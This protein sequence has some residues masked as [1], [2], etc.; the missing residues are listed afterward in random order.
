MSP[1]HVPALVGVPLSS[2]D[3]LKLSPRQVVQPPQLL[4]E[5]PD[6]ASCCEYAAPTVAVGSVM[7]VIW[8]TTFALTVIEIEADAEPATPL[9]SVARAVN[10]AVPVVVGDPEIVH[11]VNDR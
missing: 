7:V 1:E 8:Q 4:A 9:E 3:V 2:P 5:H 11:P 10:V 6:W